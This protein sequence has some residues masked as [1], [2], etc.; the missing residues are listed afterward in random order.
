MWCE[1]VND[2]A[3]AQTHKCKRRRGRQARRKSGCCRARK[4]A[5][6]T[7]M[8]ALKRDC[9]RSLTLEQRR[10][11]RG[12]RGLVCHGSMAHCLDAWVAA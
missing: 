6:V 3:R 8:Q 10:E 5:P 7:R 1:A 4:A 12:R 2:R 11:G 9:E